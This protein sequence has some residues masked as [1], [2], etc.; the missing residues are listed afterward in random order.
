MIWLRL[1]LSFET[2]V[3]QYEFTG[4]TRALSLAERFWQTTGRFPNV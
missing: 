3:F 2:I 4:K 1:Q